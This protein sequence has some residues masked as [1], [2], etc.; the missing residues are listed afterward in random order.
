[1]YSKR[2]RENDRQLKSLNSSHLTYLD[3]PL[4]HKLKPV[5]SLS[6]SFDS[7]S[8]SFSDLSLS[9]QGVYGSTHL[10]VNT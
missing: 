2:E 5:I 10:L 1:M 9:Q 4:N 7:L 3:S 6:V 8:P